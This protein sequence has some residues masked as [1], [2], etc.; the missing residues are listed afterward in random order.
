MRSTHQRQTWSSTASDVRA[1]SLS[2][3]SASAP[4]PR[5]ATSGSWSATQRQNSFMRR[6]NLAFAASTRPSRAARSARARGFRHPLLAPLARSRFTSTSAA[7]ASLACSP[8]AASASMSACTVASGASVVAD[9]LAAAPD[10]ARLAL[11]LPLLEIA[12]P[13]RVRLTAAA[14]ARPV[15][16]SGSPALLLSWAENLSRKSDVS[17]VDSTTKNSAYRRWSTSA[18]LNTGMKRQ[19]VSGS[20]AITLDTTNA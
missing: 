11:L 10:L 18:T 16:S 2:A 1:I 17:A 20:A 15:W 7:N 3:G 5:A 8:S 6:T 9:A 13:L 19:T 14:A 12:L 4:S